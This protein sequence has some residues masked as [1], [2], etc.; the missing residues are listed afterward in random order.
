MLVTFLHP[1]TSLVLVSSWTLNHKTLL[2]FLQVVCKR[3]SNI[4][5]IPTMISH[6]CTSSFIVFAVSMAVLPCILSHPLPY[7]SDNY[8]FPLTD[9]VGSWTDPMDSPSDS[10]LTLSDRYQ[11]DDLYQDGRFDSELPLPV[12]PSFDNLFKRDSRGRFTRKNRSSLN[13][14]IR[15]LM[16]RL[17]KT[18]PT[19]RASMVRFG[20]GKK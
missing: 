3:L 9:A 4:P 10:S 1:T 8:L 16:R 19:G 20:S 2:P 14:L 6:V 12:Q 11:D 7:A 15:R 13:E 17:G 18:M 5:T